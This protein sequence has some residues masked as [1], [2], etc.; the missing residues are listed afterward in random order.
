MGDAL[1]LHW[2]S[3]QAHDAAATS[4]DGITP[5][6]PPR[7]VDGGARL[8][9]SARRL[10][11]AG[12]EKPQDLFALGNDVHPHASYCILKRETLYQAEKHRRGCT[13]RE[14]AEHALFP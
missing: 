4:D 13:G 11:Q 8:F 7:L 10:R 3:E 6:A 5:E 1:C 9:A 2:R 14:P 12:E